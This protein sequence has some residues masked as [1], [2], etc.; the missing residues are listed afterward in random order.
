[1][2]EK[3]NPDKDGRSASLDMC[4]FERTLNVYNRILN[5][6]F[7]HK[8]A[9]IKNI[10]KD[11]LK[12]LHEP[13][14]GAFILLLNNTDKGTICNKNETGV[15]NKLYKSFSDFN[16][17][18]SSNDKYLQLIIIS[19]KQGTLIHRKIIKSELNKL[20]DIFFIESGCGNINDI[21]GMGWESERVGKM[22]MI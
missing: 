8:N 11:V 3:L 17:R 4:I 13:V 15:F 14:N 18:W 7:K 20:K 16:E 2:Y 12:L 9:I 5:I 1:M 6:E 21:K 10:G 22:Q 19:L